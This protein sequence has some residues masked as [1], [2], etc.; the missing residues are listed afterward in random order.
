MSNVRYKDKR[1]NTIVGKIKLSEEEAVYCMNKHKKYAIWIA[2]QIKDFSL[3]IAQDDVSISRILDW[4]RDVQEVNLN[5]YNFKTA[6]IE[7][8][9]Y[10]DSLFVKTSKS[11]ENKNVVLDCGNYKWVQ[12]VT[13][14]DCIEEG[15][16]MQN[17][18]GSHHASNI[19]EGKTV[20]FSLRDKYN[21]PHLTLEAKLDKE[22]KEIGNVFEFKGVSNKV[23][24]KK[25]LKYFVELLKKYKFKSV[26]DYTF[27]VSIKTA[28]DLAKEINNINN[29]FFDVNTKLSIGLDAF[30]AYEVHLND[31]NSGND[32]EIKINNNVK[33][34]TSVK[35]KSKVIIIEDDVLF[36]GDLYLEGEKIIFGN[37][38][39]VAGSLS[40]NS[41]NVT[42]KNKIKVFGDVF[43]KEKYKTKLG[44]MTSCQGNMVKL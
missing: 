6:L 29:T 7:A 37:N 9:E 16:A 24:K 22:K 18:I 19:S 11:L 32:K 15:K 33:F 26:S 35:I 27:M 34:Y 3:K 14:N 4:K 31:V 12:L 17:C 2:N 13:Y 5:N 43:Y 30:G 23:P 25:Y 41:K 28:F 40:V 8:N 36:G 21:K 20:A 38:I 44:N 39:K 10:F 1:F 42:N